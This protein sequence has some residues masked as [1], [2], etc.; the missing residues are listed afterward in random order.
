MFVAN[1]F[2]GPAGML[3]Q[4]DGENWSHSTRGARG[5][6]T[7]QRAVN[8]SMGLGLDEVTTDADGLHHI[9]TVVNEHGQRWTYQC[10]QEWLTADSWAAL[11]QNHSMPPTGTV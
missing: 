1:H 2:F 11:R 7:G 4:D 5:A 9:D 8:L 10:W 6:V 3:E